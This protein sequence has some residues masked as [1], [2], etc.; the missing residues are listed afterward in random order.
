MDFL[1][2]IASPVFAFFL[3]LLTTLSIYYLGRKIAPPFRPNKDKVAPYACGEYF[4]PEKV[5]MKIIFF[6]YATLFL[7]FDIV[8]MLLVFSMGIPREDPLRMNVVYMVVLYIAVVL[9]T[10]YVLMRRRLGYGVYGK[11]D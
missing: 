1:E 3:A 6:Q 2:I 10:L 11:T 5:P 4:P 9:L 8:A 7:V